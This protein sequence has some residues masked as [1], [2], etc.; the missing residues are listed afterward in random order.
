VAVDRQG[1]RP[2][3]LACALL[4]AM[5][6]CGALA[7]AAQAGQVG[8]TVQIQGSGMTTVVEGS[9]EDGGSLFCDRRS[10]KDERV[11]NGCARI[12][13]EEAFEAWVWLRPTASSV[14]EGHWRFARWSG[15][16]TT[17]VVDGHTECAVHSGAFDGVERTPKAHFEDDFA[18]TVS[19]VTETFSSTIERDV[20]YSF[21]SNEGQ[22]QC[23][24][25][26]ETQFSNCS[27]GAGR[28]YATE[29]D[30]T[31]EVRARDDSGQI[32]GSSARTVKVI[33]TALAGSGPTGLTNSRAAT[34]NYSSGAGT[35]FQCSLDFAPFTDCGPG[36][37]KTYSGLS[38][39]EHTFR[40]FATAGGGW[41]DR[42]P[43]SRTFTVDGTPPQ[44]TIANLAETPGEGAVSTLDTATFGFSS[45][46]PG[47]FECKLDA[48]AFSPCASPRIV[49]GLSAGEHTFQVRATD[50]AGNVDPTPASRTW[51]AA[52]PDAD[53][54]GYNA[55]LDCNDGDATINPGRQEILDNGVDENCDGVKGENLDRDADG[56]QRPVD[57]D[58][59]NPAIGPG[60]VDV[61]G[62]GVDDD[63]R[64][65][66]PKP[67]VEVIDVDIVHGFK[68]FRNYTKLD[69]FK[70][71][72]VAPGSTLVVRCTRKRG[73]C[74]RKARK[75]VTHVKASG[76][77]PLKSFTKA[78]LRKGTVITVTV[79]K[80]GAVGAV[81]LIRIRDRKAPQVTTLCLP[82]GSSRAEAAC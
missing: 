20:R 38:D 28:T 68:L 61:P 67:P 1:R 42:I 45:T 16:D 75:A 6:C 35:A 80:P 8:V 51:T 36:T 23:R 19:A 17:R 65:G 30:H 11:T 41:F 14:P 22:L 70:V 2:A 5:I 9:I 25:D 78:K 54:D 62:N 33:D 27:S 57:C 58:D 21:S 49:S 7:S 39:G 3:T 13:N 77:V 52:P 56:A 79:T 66:D 18:P 31:I 82:V 44:T 73:K 12:R 26:G 72:R 32:S 47:S 43:A 74:P 40:V 81:K 53:G 34:F 76:T 24:F 15:C 48:A 63:C 50:S 55:T 37:S 60:A 71:A 69:N 64:D 10:N 29:G 46:E 59:G 4:V